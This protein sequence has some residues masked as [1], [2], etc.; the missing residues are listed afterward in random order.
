MANAALTRTTSMNRA[1]HFL[2]ELFRRKVIRLLC[3]YIAVF[4]LL[5]QGFASLFPVLG[6]PDFYLKAFM[7]TNAAAF[8]LAALISWKYNFVLPALVR[9]PQ[10]VGDNNPPLS[11][12]RNHHYAA[13][14]GHIVISW[15]EDGKE[16]SERFQAPVTIGRDPDNTIRLTDKHV[17]R[18]HVVATHM[19][20]SIL[21]RER[22][23]A[24]ARSGQYQRYLRRLETSDERREAAAYLRAAV[25]SQGSQHSC[26]SRI[27]RGDCSRD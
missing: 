10:D 21:G 15:T 13:G 26:R 19:L 14:A 2:T 9:D 18:Y 7:I 4:W 8:P 23:L 22:P 1:S 17:S 20:V 5:S 16:H 24:R 6:I 27:R 25:S 11:W 3:A 12:A